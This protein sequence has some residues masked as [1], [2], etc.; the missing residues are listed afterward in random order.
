MDETNFDSRAGD[1]RGGDV[2][3]RDGGVRD[4]YAERVTLSRGGAR[5]VN[6]DSVTANLSGIREVEAQSFVLKQG[7]VAQVAAEQVDIAASAV[8]IARGQTVR[9]GPS[10]Q[11]A[12][13]LADMAVVENSLAPVVVA[14]D[15]A[16]LDQSAVGVLVSNRVALNGSAVLVAVAETVEGGAQVQV[17]PAVAAV[18]GAA[19]G[20]AL[21]VALLFGRR[22]K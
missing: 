15:Q 4:V 6:A 2:N 1:L 11:L 5:A 8:G 3:L 14:R 21:G 12:G 18:F 17:K 20:A 16:R 19:L 10:C 7:V 22:S 9:I 13:T